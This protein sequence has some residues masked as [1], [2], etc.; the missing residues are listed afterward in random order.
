MS[1]PSVPAPEQETRVV[2]HTRA[3]RA[4][5]VLLRL[6][7][8]ANLLYLGWSLAFDFFF[9]ARAA[10]PIPVAIGLVLFSGLPLALAWVIDRAVRAPLVAGEDGFAVSIGGKRIEVPRAALVE[11]RPLVVP[12]PLPG[13]V[14]RFRGFERILCTRALAAIAYDGDHPMVRFAEALPRKRRRVWWILALIVL[15][16]LISAVIFRLQQVIVYGGGFGEYYAKGLGAYL[17]SFLLRWLEIAGGLLV[18]AGVLRVLAELFV[19]VATWIF[20]RASRGL[21][22]GAE[23]FALIAYWAGVPGYL[24]FR[25][26]S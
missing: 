24:A 10:P 20:P 15:P 9:G 23:F 6:L 26:L 22:R 11:M 17:G 1:A 16:L 19:W 2:A 3:S 5:A 8:A 7:A 18:L 14:L 12:L 13:L 21:R 4:A 25:L